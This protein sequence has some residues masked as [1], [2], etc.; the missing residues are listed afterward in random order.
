LCSATRIPLGAFVDYK[1]NGNNPVVPAQRWCRFLKRNTI[2]DTAETQSKKQ[3]INCSFW[4]QDN[5][6]RLRDLERDYDW[7]LLKPTK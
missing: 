4:N 5:Q 1:L 6:R 3:D 2:E 7:S